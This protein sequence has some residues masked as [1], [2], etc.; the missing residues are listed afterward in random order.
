[1]LLPLPPL[2]DQG[3]EVVVEV[4]VVAVEVVVEVEV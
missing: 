1:M 2:L 3:V 4:L